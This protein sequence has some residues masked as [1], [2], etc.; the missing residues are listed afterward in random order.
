MGILML[1]GC[2][3]LELTSGGERVKLM[4]QDPPIDCQ[5]LTDLYVEEDDLAEAKTSLRNEAA[6]K[7]SNYVRLDSLEYF[8][9]DAVASGSAFKCSS[10]GDIPPPSND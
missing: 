3:S 8:R 6:L 1:A 4:K 9:G 5:Q 2:G 10:L 7:G